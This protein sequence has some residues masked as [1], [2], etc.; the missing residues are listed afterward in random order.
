MA[1]RQN[2][3]PTVVVPRRR[4]NGSDDDDG[5]L[6]GRCCCCCCDWVAATGNAVAF[7]STTKSKMAAH[8]APVGEEHCLAIMSSSASL[9][10]V[11]HPSPHIHLFQ[12]ISH[13]YRHDVR[14]KKE[15]IDGPLKQ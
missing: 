5:R 15:V 14:A 4:G 11:D 12:L 9:R 6:G 2:N 8:R 10:L 3:H 1:S 13:Q 7:Q